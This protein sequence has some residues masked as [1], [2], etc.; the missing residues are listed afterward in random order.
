MK[1][2]NIALCASVTLTVVAVSKVKE[3][4]ISENIIDIIE[5]YVPYCSENIIDMPCI[6]IACL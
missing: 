2:R 1:I 5:G 3:A 4:V 6:P